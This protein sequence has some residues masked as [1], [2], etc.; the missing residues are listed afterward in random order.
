MGKIRFHTFFCLFAS[1]FQSFAP[2]DSL[3]ALAAGPRF[4]KRGV[5]YSLF[6]LAVEDSP[7]GPRVVVFWLVLGRGVE[8]L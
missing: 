3:E 8:D 2:V 6:W 7:P 5:V 1:R 4:A